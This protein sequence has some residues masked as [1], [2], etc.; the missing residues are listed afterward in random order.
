[1]RNSKTVLTGIP[2]LTG[3]ASDIATETDSSLAG[4]SEP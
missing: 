2:A 3:R 4:T 1:M